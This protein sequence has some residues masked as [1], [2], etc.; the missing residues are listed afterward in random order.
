MTSYHLSAHLHGNSHTAADWIAT[1]DSHYQT[2][3]QLSRRADS[4]T[5][6]VAQQIANEIALAQYARSR[7]QDLATNATSEQSRPH[8]SEASDP[9]TAAGGDPT[10]ERPAGRLRSTFPALAIDAGTK[11]GAASRVKGTGLKRPSAPR[12]R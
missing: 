11:S 7:A 3:A 10:A 2:A 5:A 9:R 4:T 12:H 8:E 6:P 1:A